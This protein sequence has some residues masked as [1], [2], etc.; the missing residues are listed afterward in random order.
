MTSKAGTG[1]RRGAATKRI[2]LRW[3]GRAV[4]AVL[5]FWAASLV[6][7]RFAPPVST[8]MLGRWMTLQPVERIYAPLADISPHLPRAAI[9]AEDSRFCMHRG[10]DWYALS[11]VIEDAI[12]NGATR[13]A[14][15]ITMQTV[16]NVF[17]WPGRSYLRKALE[18]PLAVVLEVAWPKRRVMEAYLN[19]AEWGDGVFG[20]EAAARRYFGKSA[21]NLSRREA[22]LL[23]AALP[24]PLARNPARPSRYVSRYA[25]RI[26]GRMGNE[27]VSC[28]GA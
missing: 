12:D 1:S 22:A 20:A 23:V 26:L 6:L 17:L 19:V 24:N 3:A 27:E 2:V 10:I 14:S 11:S 4:L 9:A 16:K 21:R 18:L 15:T 8:L 13:G 7:Y 28:L 25:A 5:L